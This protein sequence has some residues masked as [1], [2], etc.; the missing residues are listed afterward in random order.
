MTAKLDD[1]SNVLETKVETVNHVAID[2]KQAAEAVLRTDEGNYGYFAV[3][4]LANLTGSGFYVLYF[5]VPPRQTI[6]AVVPP[7]STE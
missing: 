7:R 4:D 1:R 3:L 5:P 6:A 2:A